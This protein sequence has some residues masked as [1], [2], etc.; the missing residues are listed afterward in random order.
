[1]S[2]SIHNKTDETEGK[3][4]LLVEVEESAVRPET[5]LGDVFGIALAKRVR[6]KGKA[7]PIDDAIIIVALATSDPGSHIEKHQR[8]QRLLQKHLTAMRTTKPNT[9]VKKIRII[10]A[11]PDD[12][13]R[14]IKRLIPLEIGKEHK[15]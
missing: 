4:R 1:L 11:P 6:I 3:V 7:Y 14:R 12:L 5:I 9:K 8:L 13:I 10:S 15:V 2:L